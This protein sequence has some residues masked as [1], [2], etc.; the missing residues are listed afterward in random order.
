MPLGLDKK[1]FINFSLITAANFFFFSNFS[2]FFLL[3]LYIKELGGTEAD[4]GFIMGSFGITSLGS[5]PFV[6]F[7][8]DRYGRKLFMFAGAVIMLLSSLL[9]IT[10]DELSALLYVFRRT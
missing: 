7:L 3:P 8:I 1:G 4:I 10:I 9:F 5:I 2:T 6:T